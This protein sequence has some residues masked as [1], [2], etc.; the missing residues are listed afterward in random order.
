M[1]DNDK[2]SKLTPMQFGRVQLALEKQ[3]RFADGVRTLREELQRMAAIAPIEKTESDGMIDWNR[4]TFN[5]LDY[6]GQ[7]AY[8]ARLKAKRY[9]Y[10]SGLV[11]PK[12]VYDAIK[13]NP[14][15]IAA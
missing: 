9:Y 6:K 4:T 1:F 5:R 3:Y 13:D 11:V 10:A 2:L 15:S 7:A 8:E 12:I 14:A